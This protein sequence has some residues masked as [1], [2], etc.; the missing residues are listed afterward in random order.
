MEID[1]TDLCSH[2]LCSNAAFALKQ[3]RELGSWVGECDA[4]CTCNTVQKIQLE[5][6]SVFKELIGSHSR[7]HDQDLEVSNKNTAFTLH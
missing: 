3:C 4:S 5:G 1:L 7:A 2:R 6:Q